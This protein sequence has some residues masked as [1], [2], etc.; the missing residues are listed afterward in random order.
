MGKST[1]TN[2]SSSTQILI[3]GCNIMSEYFFL[4]CNI[5]SSAYAL[6]LC[7]FVQHYDN[8]KIRPYSLSHWRVK[9][10]VPSF[11]LCFG[12]ITTND[13][14]GLKAVWVLGMA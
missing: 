11:L 6:I 2:T 12:Y 9:S 5:G 13:L 14:L 1:T 8:F 7:S 4:R 3:S 10:V